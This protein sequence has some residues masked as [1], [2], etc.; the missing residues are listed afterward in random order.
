M[1]LSTTD[2]PPVLTTPCSG[3]LSV[4]AEFK[5]EGYTATSDLLDKS[6]LPKIRDGFILSI[7][8]P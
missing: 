4:P 7:K 1:K 5:R 2:L 3:P 6:F 8:N